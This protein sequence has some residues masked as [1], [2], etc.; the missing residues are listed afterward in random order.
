MA[1]NPD[2]APPG[3]CAVEAPNGDCDAC[4][5]FAQGLGCRESR[6]G[7]SCDDARAD[8]RFVVFR[9]RSESVYLEQ[10]RG[11]RDLLVN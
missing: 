10:P 2:D 9:P 4:A 1:I 3:Y 8:G 6:Q 11:F 5:F 7:V